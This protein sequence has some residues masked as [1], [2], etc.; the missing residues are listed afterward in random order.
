MITL[1]IFIDG[2][3]AKTVKVPA[4]AGSTVPA[5]E[6]NPL[7]AFRY[8]KSDASWEVP[9]RVIRL[10]SATPKYF[11]GLDTGDKNRFKKFLRAKATSF[12]LLEFAPESMS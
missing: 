7:V 1:N 12:E 11:L 10:I 9:V 6:S 5:I 4:K 2:A 3:K 8:P